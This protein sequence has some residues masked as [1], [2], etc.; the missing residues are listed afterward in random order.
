M[1]RAVEEWIGKTADAPIP[2]RVKLRVFEAHGGRC[3]LSGRKIM[4]GEL[5]ECDHVKALS[6]HPQMREVRATLE[7]LGYEVT[8]R[9]I[10]GGHELTKEGSTEAD[11]AE[12]VRYALEDW[13]D[14]VAADICISFTEEPRKTTTRGG[15]H[16]E[17][18]AALALGK[19]CIVIGH[20]ENVFHCLPQVG[21][22]DNLDDAVAVL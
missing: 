14:L 16:V 6:R 11:E 20:R 12:R 3:H 8:S 1:S 19:G 21:F 13:A 9:W 5:W 18:G 7:A 2:P 22:F 15:R 10:N 17:F 4:P